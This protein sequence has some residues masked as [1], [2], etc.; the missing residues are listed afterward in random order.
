M[1]Q[2]QN[3]ISV[4]MHEVARRLA[5]GRQM[6]LAGDKALAQ[7][8]E[9]LAE[10]LLLSYVGCE[11]LLDDMLTAWETSLGSCPVICWKQAGLL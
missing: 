11:E 4:T 1:T 7:Y 8:W 10:R 2:T 5:R 9:E 3:T 6:R